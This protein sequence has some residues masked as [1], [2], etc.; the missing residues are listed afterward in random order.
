LDGL[1]QQAHEIFANDPIQQVEEF[2]KAL[3]KASES[4]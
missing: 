1:K 3:F 4:E 2:K